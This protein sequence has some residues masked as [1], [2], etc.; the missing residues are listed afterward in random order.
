MART[1]GKRKGTG[2]AIK[3]R[4]AKAATKKKETAK[5]AVRKYETERKAGGLKSKLFRGE[6]GTA[7]RKAAAGNARGKEIL[8]KSAYKK[9]LRKKRKRQ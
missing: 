7:K 5:A 8:A 4:R 9:A 1:M 2:L 3:R 6:P